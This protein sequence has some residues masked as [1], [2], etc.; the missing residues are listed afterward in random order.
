MTQNP[1]T[2]RK[3]KPMAEKLVEWLTRKELAD[4]WKMPR[5]TLDQWA[6]LGFGPPYAMFGRHARYRMS[7]VIRWENEQFNEP[8]E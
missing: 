1:T 4:R 2:E 8:G 7:D 6:Y 3:W 5:A